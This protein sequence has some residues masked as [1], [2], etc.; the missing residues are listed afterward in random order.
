[1]ATTEH[2]LKLK[3]VLDTA[4]VRADLA[5]LRQQQQRIINQTTGGSYPS[6]G[7]TA[8]NNLANITQLS[9]LLNKLTAE[10]WRLDS[11]VMKLTSQMGR[12]MMSQQ[13]MLQ[14]KQSG[15]PGGLPYV[16]GSILGSAGT[17]FL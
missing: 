7:F 14:P 3:A 16:P 13:P 4:Q 12:Q 9:N 10:I 6:G 15:N 2:V 17:K 5:K 8:Q 11:S 1:M